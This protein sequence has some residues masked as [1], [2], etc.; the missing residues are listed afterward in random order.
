MTN[1]KATRSKGNAA[2]NQPLQTYEAWRK[3]NKGDA[4]EWAKEMLEQLG[5]TYRELG[6]SDR[7]AVRLGLADAE[8]R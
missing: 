5:Q 4:R 2:S 6:P 3:E 7:Y 8:G 1:A